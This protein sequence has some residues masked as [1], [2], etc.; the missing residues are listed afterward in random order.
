MSRPA[1]L[2]PGRDGRDRGRARGRVVQPVPVAVGG[3]AA[4]TGRGTER[5]E[6]VAGHRPV[7][8]ETQSRSE[9]RSQLG[10][11][12][13]GGDP[14]RDEDVDPIRE[15][16]HVGEV[17]ACQQ[18]RDA[19][20][21]QVRHDPARGRPALGIHAGGGFIEDH[22]VRLADERE[23][24]AEALPLPARQAPIAGG[25]DLGEPDK[26]EKGVGVAGFLVEPGVLTHGLARSGPH[27]DAAGLEHQSDAGPERPPARGRVQAEDA[28]ATAV[29]AAEPLDDLDGRGL[30]RA[31]G[32]EQRDDLAG[33][34]GQGHTVDDGP[35]AVPLD[36]A[37]DL[38]GRAHGAIL[39]YW[40][41]KSASVSSPIWIDRMMPSLSTK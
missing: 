27:V 8:P 38:D 2:G 16:L 6:L 41:S 21:A 20:V 36:Q 22:D 35:V 19:L 24:E 31:V 30:A 23:R 4:A 15:P 40:R 29:G 25:G 34:D 17:V 1:A 3:D 32:P 11:R 12:A 28:R 18:D 33:L 14:T 10:G 13:R 9:A 5:L 26:L 39:A 37:I 7:H